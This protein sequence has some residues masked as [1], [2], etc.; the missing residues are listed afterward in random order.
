MRSKISA[1][2]AK[3]IITE[4]FEKKEYKFITKYFS[5][6]DFCKKLKETKLIYL[7]NP[8]FKLKFYI[9]WVS[10]RWVI[11][12]TKSWNLVPLMI[13]LKKE[14]DWKNIIWDTYKNEILEKQQKALED[15]EL[16]KFKTY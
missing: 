4:H 13:S 16:N 3:I 5:L 8:Y 15:I 7:K 14:K 2:R 9:W 12:I 1:L 11:L 10:F 6:E